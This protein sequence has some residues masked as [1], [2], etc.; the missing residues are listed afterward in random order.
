[1]LLFVDIILTC[2]QSKNK[3]KYPE[4]NEQY[5]YICS[6]VS[7]DYIEPNSTVEYTMYLRIVRFE[8]AE[9]EEVVQA[10]LEGWKKYIFPV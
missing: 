1:M 10:S 9:G 3:R 8:V 5:K 6:G 7:F 4:Q 2:T